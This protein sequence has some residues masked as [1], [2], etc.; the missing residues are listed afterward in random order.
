[1]SG[2]LNAWPMKFLDRHRLLIP[3]DAGGSNGARL[4]LWKVELQKLADELRM[5]IAVCHFPPGTSKWNKIERRLFSFISQN[6][7][8]QPLVSHEVIVKL[9]ASTR[10]RR[11]S[12]CARVSTPRRIPLGSRSPG[13]PWPRSRSAQIDSMATGTTRFFPVSMPITTA[14]L[15]QLFCDGP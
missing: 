6:W 14:N 8:G 7:R 15:V 12:G 9:I 13:T 4:R 5:P 10:P 3:A 1:L 2:D 11:A